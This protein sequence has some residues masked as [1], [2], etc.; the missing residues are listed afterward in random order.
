MK[1]KAEIEF[2]E[3]IPSSEEYKNLLKEVYWQ[4][5]PTEV[6][7]IGL[8]NSLFSICA[9]CHGK[10][11]GLGRVIGDDALYFEIVDVIVSNGYQRKQVGYSIVSKLMKYINSKASKGSSVSLLASKGVASFYEKFGFKKRRDESP[12]MFIHWE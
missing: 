6:V 5:V 1:V 3:K 8:N 7:K 9:I 2:I 4:N 10:V 12:G 11:I